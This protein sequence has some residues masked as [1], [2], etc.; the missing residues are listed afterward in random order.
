MINQ[1]L[2]DW[3]SGLPQKF[4]IHLDAGVLGKT[5]PPTGLA[6]L[7]IGVV[8]I[9]ID[10]VWLQFG[11]GVIV[12]ALAAY[13]IRESFRY[14]HKFPNHALL[15]GAKLIQAMRLEQAAKGITIDGDA[16]PTSNPSLIERRGERDRE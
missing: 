13:Y 7:A 8:A 16:Q 4:G 6:V 15:E 3:L 9:S 10:N 14:A 11:L 1:S 5:A 12:A 2:K